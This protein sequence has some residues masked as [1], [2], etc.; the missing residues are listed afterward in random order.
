[1]KLRV[2]VADDMSSM[3]RHLVSLLETEFEVVSTAENGKLALECIPRARLTLPSSIS[4][5]LFL[6]E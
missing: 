2:V 4:A 3:L 5:C 1:V 6:T